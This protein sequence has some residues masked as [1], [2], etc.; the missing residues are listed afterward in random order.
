M[1]SEITAG[2]D[3]IVCHVDDILIWG[4]TKEQHDSRVH[5]VLEWAKKAGMTLNM[6]KCEFGRQEVK[7]LG[8]IISAEGVKSDTDKTKAVQDI[9]GANEHQ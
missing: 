9:R 5:A 2:L 6:A 1:T 7:F 3:G 8:H 4:D